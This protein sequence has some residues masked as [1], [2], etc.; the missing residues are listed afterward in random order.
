MGLIDK[1]EAARR[2]ARVI[3]SDIELYNTEKIRAGLDL[4]REINEGYRLFRTRVSPQLVS[5]FAEVVAQKGKSGNAA[6]AI[7]LEAL[8]PTGATPR[9]FMSAPAPSAA[10]PVSSSVSLMAGAAISGGGALS[11][12]FDGASLAGEELSRGKLSKVRL[13]TAL[14]ALVGA[15]F[16]VSRFFTH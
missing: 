15:G 10:T 11:S 8:G 3:L 6:F 2:L 12:S 14:V 1:E 4:R 13:L 7:P 5:L 9:P 16:L